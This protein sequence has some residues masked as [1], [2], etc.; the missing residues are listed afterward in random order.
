M[1]QYDFEHSEKDN[2]GLGCWVSVVFPGSEGVTTSFV[3][4]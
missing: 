3:Y 1:D 2:T 4:G